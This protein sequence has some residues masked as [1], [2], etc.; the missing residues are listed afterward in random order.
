MRY[1]LSTLL[2]WT[3]VGPMAL[4]GAWTLREDI[5]FAIAGIAQLFG[6]LLVP[7]ALIAIVTT[8]LAAA[9][10]GFALAIAM[11]LLGYCQKN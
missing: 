1:S 7:S 6:I 9:I 2:I 11:L 8:L 5:A 4:A 10:L 3:A